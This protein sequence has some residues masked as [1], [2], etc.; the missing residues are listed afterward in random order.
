MQVPRMK[1]SRMKVSHMKM[2]RMKTYTFDGHQ[3]RG[4]RAF[5]RERRAANRASGGYTTRKDGSVVHRDFHIRMGRLSAAPPALPHAAA[6]KPGTV[7]GQCRD[8]TTIA[9]DVIDW[10]CRHAGGVGWSHRPPRI[11]GFRTD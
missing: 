9:S 11:Q 4:Y 10:G 2:S 3:I 8:G 7:Q 6:P 1:V 5:S